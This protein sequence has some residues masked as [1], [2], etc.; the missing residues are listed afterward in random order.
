M[1]NLRRPGALGKDP[2]RAARRTE[3]LAAIDPDWDCLWPLDWRR[4]Y[5]V[6]RNCLDSGASLAELLPGV[7]IDGDDIGH[8]LAPQQCQRPATLVLIHLLW[9]R[10]WPS[11]MPGRMGVRVTAA[12][13]GPPSLTCRR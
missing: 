9:S 6:V 4:Q 2:E 1:A 3:Q 8:W 5:T 7:Q 13:S 12:C 10:D 11:Q